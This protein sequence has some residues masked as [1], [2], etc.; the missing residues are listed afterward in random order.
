MIL[1]IKLTNFR[2]IWSYWLINEDFR[3]MQIR[4]FNLKYKIFYSHKILWGMKKLTPILF[5]KFKKWFEL[6]QFDS[7]TV[8]YIYKC[9]AG[10]LTK[11][12]YT[13]AKTTKYTTNYIISKSIFISCFTHNLMDYILYIFYMNYNLTISFVTNN[14]S[15]FLSK[16]QN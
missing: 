13:Y 15:S 9:T 5:T 1:T 10:F 11:W 6:F 2:L 16:V 4:N 14:N 7:K 8:I 3:V 12:R